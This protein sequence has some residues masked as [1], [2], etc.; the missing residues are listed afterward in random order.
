LTKN[1]YE[2]VATFSEDV[3]GSPKASTTSVP[4]KIEP[5]EKLEI[6]LPLE[7]VEINESTTDHPAVEEI[8]NIGF[9]NVGTKTVSRAHELENSIKKMMENVRIKSN[10]KESSMIETDI[11]NLQAEMIVNDEDVNTVTV[12]PSFEKLVIKQTKEEM[13][14]E[15]NSS[16][17]VM[18]NFMVHKVKESEETAAGNDVN[19]PAT[20]TAPT[21]DKTTT[22][23]KMVPTPLTKEDADFKSRR[24][25]LFRNHNGK[26]KKGSLLSKFKKL[27]RSRFRKLQRNHKPGSTNSSS[28]QNTIIEK[29]KSPRKII[30]RKN[31]IRGERRRV[32][33]SL[34]ND[35]LVK[36]LQRQ[37]ESQKSK[38]FSSR[39]RPFTKL[40]TTSP[41]TEK[42][43]TK[44]KKTKE[45][46]KSN[47]SNNLI[48]QMEKMEIMKQ[49]IEGLSSTTPM[50]PF[51][52]ITTSDIIEDDISEGAVTDPNEDLETTTVIATSISTSEAFSYFSS[53]SLPEE[54]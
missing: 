48:A 36:S 51:S 7:I 6:V 10:L 3:I 50:T 30:F 11:Q 40:E 15:Q 31:L 13:M 27:D 44:D 28:D 26:I 46:D 9:N 47:N 52:D 54:S 35:P 14:K 20:T 37:I 16:D 41:Q 18:T 34:N 32:P 22:H 45:G 19:E 4:E 5:E 39:K 8:V 21:A 12:R 25:N 38:L 24:R 23:A 53:A 49:D 33:A 17:L 1:F 42:T 2:R 43:T 29:K